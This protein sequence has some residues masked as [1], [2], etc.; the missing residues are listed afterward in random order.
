M[1]TKKRTFAPHIDIEQVITEQLFFLSDNKK[2]SFTRNVYSFGVM[3]KKLYF[4]SY[5]KKVGCC[6]K[7]VQF[8]SYAQKTICNILR[9][10]IF[11]FLHLFM[12]CNTLK[13]T[14]FEHKYFFKS[15]ENL[16]VYQHRRRKSVF[17]IRFGWFLVVLFQIAL[18]KCTL[19][20]IKCKDH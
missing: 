2:G 14:T 7:C 4:H 5:H 10:Y 11:N 19:S 13:Y 12:F 20:I 16:F 6:S 17:P 15:L 9:E 18:L 8:S 1:I 3:T